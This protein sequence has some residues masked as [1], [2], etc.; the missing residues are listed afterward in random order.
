MFQV[1]L[2]AMREQAH[3]S[4]AALAKKVGVAQST[5]GMWESGR[6]KPENA[7]L[8]ALANLFNVTTDYL[9]G[10]DDPTPSLDTQLSDI[11]F[12]LSGEIRELSDDEK[13]DILDYVRF[14]RAQK[15]R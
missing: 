14:K 4:Q 11:D 9:L 3:L 1:R 8:E 6:N 5:V 7:K 15:K 10:R 12:A 2:K 13:Q